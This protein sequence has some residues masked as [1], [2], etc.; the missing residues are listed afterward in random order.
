MDAEN[1]RIPYTV[2]I[3][4]RYGGFSMPEREERMSCGLS[5]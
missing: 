2:V 1:E 3:I 4:Q 5:L